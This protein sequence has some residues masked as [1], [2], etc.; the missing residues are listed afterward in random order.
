MKVPG[1][2][3]GRSWVRAYRRPPHVPEGEQLSLPLAR[4]GPA[5][6]PRQRDDPDKSDALPRKRSRR[7]SVRR[8]AAVR[9]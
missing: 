9:G 8:G 2:W 5:R 3:R 6:I 1:Y 7:V 4:A